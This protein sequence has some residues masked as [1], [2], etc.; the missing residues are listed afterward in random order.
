MKNTPALACKG[1]HIWSKMRTLAWSRHSLHG[2][3]WQEIVWKSQFLKDGEVWSLFCP[4]LYLGWTKG[5]VLWA[6]VARA[7]GLLVATIALCI[8][9][10]HSVVIGLLFQYLVTAGLLSNTFVYFSWVLVGSSMAGNIFCFQVPSQISA[11]TQEGT[12]SLAHFP[13]TAPPISPLPCSGELLIVF[14]IPN[15]HFEN[16][17]WFFRFFSEKNIFCPSPL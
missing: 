17:F 6:N 15:F 14:A 10:T 13:K 16:P 2:G 1:Y 7:L 12:L 11:H 5:P 4:W 8:V 3:Q 9:D